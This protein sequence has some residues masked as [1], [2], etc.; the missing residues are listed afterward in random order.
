VRQAEQLSDALAPLGIA[1]VFSSPFVRTVA[2]AKPFAQKHALDILIVDDLR[3]RLIVNDDRHPSEEIWCKSWDDFSFAPPKCE[4]S[5]AAQARISKAM[6]DIARTV[7]GTSAVFTHGNV[8]GLFLN[9]QVSSFGRKECEALTNP[10][11]LKIEWSG[12]R[13]KWDRDFS[14]R[15][16]EHIRT[17]HAQTP[18]EEV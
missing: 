16:L 4:S 5:A 1:Q 10:D 6:G 9:A 13:F 14:L 18:R 8:M 7:T 12:G 3:E 17:H 2:T 11:V 15:G